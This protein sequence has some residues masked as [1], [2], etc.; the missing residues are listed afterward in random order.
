MTFRRRSPAPGYGAGVFNI[1]RHRDDDVA[2][3]AAGFPGMHAVEGDPFRCDRAPFPLLR[4]GDRRTVERVLWRDDDVHVVRVFDYRYARTWGNER[5]RS[6]L[7]TCA[8]ALANASWPYTII[9]P[10]TVSTD[11]VGPFEGEDRHLTLDDAFDDAFVVNTADARFVSA[12]LEPGDRAFLLDKA[13]ALSIE[14]N[15]AWVLVSAEDVP[16]Q[17]LPALFGF[18]DDLLQHLER[19]TRLFCPGPRPGDLHQPMPDP[20]AVALEGLTGDGAFDRDALGAATNEAD[21][22]LGFSRLAPEFLRDFATAAGGEAVE[23]AIRR[24]MLDDPAWDALDESPLDALDE[25]DEV[26]YDL[27]GN[28]IPRGIQNPWGE[29]RVAP[30]EGAH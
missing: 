18:L 21:V 15:G 25:A 19:S 8:T 30:D 27:D 11:L 16:P 26:E 13:R 3:A 1:F 12:F 7:F 10:A 6:P 29:G 22:L 2:Y 9:R 17:L 28:V 14:L 5:M 4:R 23:Q 24:Q 20:A